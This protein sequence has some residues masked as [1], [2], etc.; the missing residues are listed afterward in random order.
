MT[1][2]SIP[3]A[4]F[5]FGFQPKAMT[6]VPAVFLWISRP[7]M[8]LSKSN[9]INYNWI[10]TCLKGGTNLDNL[11]VPFCSSVFVCKSS[12]FFGNLKIESFRFQIWIFK[13]STWRT[14]IEINFG[15]WNF[16][17]I[18]EHSSVGSPLNH[19][20]YSILPIK[21]YGTQFPFEGRTM[22]S[23]GG[24]PFS[25]TTKILWDRMLLGRP[26][27]K[28]TRLCAMQRTHASMMRHSSRH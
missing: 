18:A 12:P 24:E 17:Y 6:A 27:W 10:G 8:L 9:P 19:G 25:G 11:D 13:I 26:Y 20:R 7:V 16:N 1:H 22:P 5:Y 21:I 4:T 28:C 15:R 14:K 3:T 2:Y 23:D